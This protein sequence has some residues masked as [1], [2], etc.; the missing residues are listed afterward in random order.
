MLS[1]SAAA[2]VFG[3]TVLGSGAVAASGYAYLR[4]EMGEDALNR[5]VRFDSLL[6]PC[7]LEYKLLEFRCERLPALLGQP[8]MS[9]AE[10]NAAFAPLHA[11]MK[12]SAAAYYGTVVW[13]MQKLF[14]SPELI[15]TKAAYLSVAP[16]HSPRGRR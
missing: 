16:D 6:I 3:A 4:N 10:E 8:P 2:K 11:A 5:L 12:L 13:S 14:A 7:V 15:A 1:A 9:S